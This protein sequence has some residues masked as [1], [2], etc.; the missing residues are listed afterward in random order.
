VLNLSERSSELVVTVVP[1]AAAEL[2][3][4]LCAFSFPPDYDT[5]DLGA[6]WFEERR[7]AIPPDLYATIALFSAPNGTRLWGNL[8]GL[9]HETPEP[10]DV[11]AFLA[12]LRATPPEEVRRHLLGHYGEFDPAKREATRLAAA[13]DPA[14][15][16]ETLAM[17]FAD[18][19]HR[20]EVRARYFPAD[21][22]GRAKAAL[23][24]TLA[25]WQ[26]TVFAGLEPEIVPILE[27]DAKAKRALGRGGPPERLLDTALNGVE[28]TPEPGIREVVLFPCYLWRPWVVLSDHRDLKLVVYPVADDSLALGGDE[29]PARL[30]KLYKALGDERR[31]RTLKRLAAGDSTLQDLA[32]HLGLAKSTMHHHLAIL[33]VAG[34]VRVRMRSASDMQYSLRRDLL[35]E[36]GELLRGYLG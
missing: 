5:F 15:L 4:S 11:P 27:R 6:A 34:L 7:A 36:V 16:D 24:E 1:S 25:R 35:P 29:P 19:G 3:S 9:V 8:L 26:E 2:L 32:D 23:L 10:R 18:E 21:D 20:E 13:G 30:V 14:A 33:R 12:H 31:L 17:F 22:P 28:Y